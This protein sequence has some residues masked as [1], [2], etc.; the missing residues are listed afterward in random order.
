MNISYTSQYLRSVIETWDIIFLEQIK[1]LIWKSF[2][3]Y[4]FSLKCHI[5]FFI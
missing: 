1:V 3:K 5:L 2:F 4:K